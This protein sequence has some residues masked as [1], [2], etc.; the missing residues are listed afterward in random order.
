VTL[1]ACWVMTLRAR[2]VDAKS[3][4]G[5]VKVVEVPPSRMFWAV[6]GPKLS[7]HDAWVCAQGRR[8]RRAGREEEEEELEEE[9]EE[10]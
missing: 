5:D 2:W 4:L 7:S 1:R 6:L 10:G 3:S 9:E 8:R